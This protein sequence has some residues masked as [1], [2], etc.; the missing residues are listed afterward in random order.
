MTVWIVLGCIVLFFALFLSQRIKVF[1]KLGDELHLRAGLGP[2]VL[3]LAPKKPR[4]PVNPDDFAYEKHQKRLKKD[5]LKSDKKAAKKKAKAEKKLQA[6]KLAEEA[7]KAAK[8]TEEKA[9]E[10]KL[11]TILALIGFVLDEL[12]VLS[13]S[14]RTDVRALHVTVGGSEAD[15]IAKTYG[16]LSGSVAILLELL[17]NKTTMKPLKP[18]AAW[19]QAD[20]LLA[21]TKMELD[22]S[23]KISLFSL[24]RTG[25]HTLLWFVRQKLTK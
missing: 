3:T 2:I 15:K 7:E 18:G 10:H 25:W 6:K 22:F 5:K 24:F 11:E 21:K 23:F 14:I 9:D 20:F 1:V 12:P 17:E 13:K 8:S 19:V 16:I 4:K